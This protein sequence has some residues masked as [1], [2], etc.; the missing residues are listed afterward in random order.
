MPLLLGIPLAEWLLGGTA[1]GAAGWLYYRPGGTKD[2]LVDA[3]SKPSAVQMS[4]QAD[5]AASTDLDQ[6]SAT[7]ACS[8]CFPPECRNLIEK[9]RKKIES[10]LAEKDKYAPADDAVGGFPF[11]AG[12]VLK[13]TSPGGHYK[14]MRALQRGL[15]ND[16]EAYNRNQCYDKNPTDGDKFIRKQAERLKSDDVEVPPGID[17]EPL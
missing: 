17:F 12:G 9:M 4:E 16:L 6:T 3:L 10:Y 11:M 5:E 15:K 13:K 14:E 7:D 2:Q 1:L 8:T